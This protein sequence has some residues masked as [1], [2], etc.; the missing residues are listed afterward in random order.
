[1][2]KKSEKEELNKLLRENERVITISGANIIYVEKELRIIKEE[3]KNIDRKISI[4][5]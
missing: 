4:L 3:M 5:L 2:S 1:M